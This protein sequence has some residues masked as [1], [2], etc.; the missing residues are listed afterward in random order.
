MDPAVHKRFL[1]YR[2]L[3]VYFAK[4]VKAPQLTAAEFADADGEH[5]AL[6]AKGDA[7][8]DE[9]DARFEALAK[10]LFRD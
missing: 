1:E 6:A 4:G 7:R 9:E 2:E 8:D 10:L 3:Y 5:R